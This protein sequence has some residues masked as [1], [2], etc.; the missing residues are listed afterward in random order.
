MELATQTVVH[1]SGEPARRLEQLA[2]ERGMTEEALVTQALEL[3]FRQSEMPDS[4]VDDWELLRRMEAEL[5]PCQAR[6]K[7]PMDPSHFVV[8]HI[9][10][11][12]PDSICRP[13]EVR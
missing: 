3:L 4:E 1:L 10:P 6:T 5:G 2:S 13:G 9:T 12:H 8:T 7:P 11:L